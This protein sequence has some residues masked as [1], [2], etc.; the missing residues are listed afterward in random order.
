MVF[1]LIA[2]S[3]LT[4][5]MAASS[6]DLPGARYKLLHNESKAGKGKSSKSVGKSSKGA[7]DDL[8]SSNDDAVVYRPHATSKSSKMMMEMP[9]LLPVADVPSSSPSMMM[10]TVMPSSSP[11]VDDSNAPTAKLLSTT[12][13]HRPSYVDILSHHG[14]DIGME[15]SSSPMTGH[16]LFTPSVENH[17]DVDASSFSPST[18]DNAATASP[19]PSFTIEASSSP[20]TNVPSI[21]SFMSPTVPPVNEGLFGPSVVQEEESS[22]APT[23]SNEDDTGVDTEGSPFSITVTLSTGTS[24]IPSS[25]PSSSPSLFSDAPTTSKD[26]NLLN[27]EQSSSLEGAVASLMVIF[28]CALAIM[29]T[30]FGVFKVMK[31]EEANVLDEYGAQLAGAAAFDADEIGEVNEVE[32]GGGDVDSHLQLVTD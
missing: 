26:L 15:P 2:A 20:S 23:L 17:H 8:I 7:G 12:P 19:A 5:T 4:T 3:T 21:V 18:A 22:I 30:L 29:G 28:A 16:N 31:R 27:Q 25:T 1:I 10:T 11:T 6:N 9:L 32:G 13:T 14:H 24:L